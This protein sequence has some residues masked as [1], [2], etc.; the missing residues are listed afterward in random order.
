[1]HAKVK[2]SGKNPCIHSPVLPVPESPSITTRYL[3]GGV[4]SDDSLLFE[5]PV[6]P[7]QQDPSKGERSL[8]LKRSEREST[9]EEFDAL[10]H[11]PPSAAAAA[12]MNN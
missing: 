4:G 6:Y 9:S 1:L 12:R 7:P 5:L 11:H 2:W 3:V 10:R 8:N